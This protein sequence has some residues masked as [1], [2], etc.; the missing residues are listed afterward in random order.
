MSVL[1]KA[2]ELERQRQEILAQGAEQAL[3]NATAAL[4]ELRE[5]IDEQ[6]K[7]IERPTAKV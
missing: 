3:Q 5:L 7:A 4:K 2:R 1:E 6:L